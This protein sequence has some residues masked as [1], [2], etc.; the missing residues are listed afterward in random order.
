MVDFVELHRTA[1][2]FL[3]RSYPDKKIYTAWP[4]TQA[5]RDPLFGYV[6]QKLTA[7]ETSDLR[8]STLEAIDPKNVDVLVM[9]SRTWEPSWGVLHWPFV[10][11]FLAHFYEYERQ[12][13]ASEVRERFG[14][15]PIRHWTQRGQW[16]EIYS[17]F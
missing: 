10:Q 4:L 11:R 14:L 5:L 15:L 6:D 9:Y 13:N 3:E 17:R 1:A 2:K 16:I 8:Y 12:M 7:M